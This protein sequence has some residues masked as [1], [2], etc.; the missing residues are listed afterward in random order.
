MPMTPAARIKCARCDAIATVPT[1]PTHTASRPDIRP[2]PSKNRHS[3]TGAVNTSGIN[4]AANQG[5]ALTPDNSAHSATWLQART[6]GTRVR[7][8]SQ[9]TCDTIKP[10]A[11]THGHSVCRQW[12]RCR[13]G[14]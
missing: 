9:S 6:P 11:E 12:N 4:S 8:T 13:N 3:T 7:A 14:P 5:A 10:C 2:K 1:T